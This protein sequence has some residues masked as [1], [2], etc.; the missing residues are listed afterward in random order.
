[1]SYD[2]EELRAAVLNARAAVLN[3][4]V[5]AMVASNQLSAIEGRHPVW[6]AYDFEAAIINCQLSEND[7]HAVS[8]LGMPS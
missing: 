4:K 2:T 3:A 1:M 6:L 5:A 7:I 8:I